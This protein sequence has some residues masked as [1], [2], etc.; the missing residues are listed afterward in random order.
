MTIDIAES[1]PEIREGVR[2][3]CASYPGAYWRELDA[4]RAYPEAFVKELTEAGYL[5]SL[6]PEEYVGSGLP[7][8][9]GCAILVAVQTA[10]RNGAASFGRASCRE[11]V[12]MYV[13]VRIGAVFITHIFLHLTNPH[14]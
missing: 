9:A 11:S 4:Q 6:V 12:W 5:S 8:A 14:P 3:L 10:G 1:F 7:L 2:A 13:Y